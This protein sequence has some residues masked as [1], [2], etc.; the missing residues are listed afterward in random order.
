MSA[1]VKEGDLAIVT[2]TNENGM[3][4][5]EVLE[6]I[7]TNHKTVS[8][9]KTPKAYVKQK[10]DGMEYVEYSYMRDI[11]NKYYPDWCWTVIK[12]EFAG[13]AAYVVHGRLSWT[14]NGLKKW[15]DATASHRIQKK[16]GSEEY[17]DLGN[18]IKAA[19]TD[20]IKK[21]FNMFMNIS[22]DIYRNQIEETEL[23][24]DEKEE[25]I[26]IARKIDENKGSEIAKMVDEGTI[27]GL[28]YKGALA[29]LKRQAKQ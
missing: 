14:E 10:F 24:R 20:C 17:V 9:V 21:A 8:S 11:A 2:T 13:T 3:V 12:T 19:N 22:D 4:S 23:T 15:G 7:T 6:S 25:I 27:H 1:N 16:R 26:L 5:I 18:D 29:K 28:N